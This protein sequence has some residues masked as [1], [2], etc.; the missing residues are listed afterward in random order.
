[1]GQGEQPGDGLGPG[2]GK[3]SATAEGGAGVYAARPTGS[4]SL[5]GQPYGNT[6]ILP[7]IGGSGGGGRLGGSFYGGGGGGGAILIASN[8]KISLLPGARILATGGGAN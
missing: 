8:T 2:A 1:N 7:L 5:D 4:Y 6:L 3:G